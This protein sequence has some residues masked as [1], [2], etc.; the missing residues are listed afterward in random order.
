MDNI[1]KRTSANWV[2]YDKYEW[3]EAADGILYLTP[4]KDAVMSLYNPIK[5]Y[6]ELVLTALGI[7]LDVMQKKASMEELK[8]RIQ[9]F[10]EHFGLLGL[11]TALPTTPEFITY[12]AVY[13]PKNHLIRQETLSTEDYLSY[14][15]PFDKISFRKNG[16]ESVWN[17]DN[18]EML[19]VIMAMQDKPQAVLMSF[20]K[21][22]AEP[23]NWIT[24]VF[25]DWA[26]TFV[27]SFLY[28]QDYDLLDEEEKNVYRKGM[29]CFGGIAP[30]YHIELLDK[31]TIVWDF[32][33]LMLAI[34]MM[35]S[36][37]ITD[38]NSTL[39][40]CKHCGKIFVASRSNVQFCSP[41]CKNQHNVYKCRAKKEDS[42]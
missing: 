23:Y 22:Y 6:E 33:S 19:A 17:S 11:M 14:F 32:N 27:T 31:P 34:Q 30:T 37:M 39:K 28:Y 10:A 29:E 26:F 9:S 4:A 3:K 2:R 42:A 15:F 24:T 8:Q 1:F 35:F 20:Q 18:L 12:D 13:L 36:F 5:E 40:L 38:G 21:E 41:Q 25:S 7:G 16:Q